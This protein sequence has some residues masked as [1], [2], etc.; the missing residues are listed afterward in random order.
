MILKFVGKNLI[1]NFLSYEYRIIRTI[2]C[3][4]LI[5]KKLCVILPYTVTA[6]NSIYSKGVFNCSRKNDLPPYIA[7]DKYIN[8]IVFY[9]RKDLT[10]NLPTNL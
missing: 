10:N 7:G 2:G 3:L 8:H 9:L 4:L 6:T 1:L 5:P